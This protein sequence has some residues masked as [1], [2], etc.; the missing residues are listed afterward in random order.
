MYPNENLLKKPTNLEL[1]ISEEQ[2]IEEGEN[3]NKFIS[4]SRTYLEVVNRITKL[5]NWMKICNEGKN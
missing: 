4:P 1:I 5:A 3:D 2:Y